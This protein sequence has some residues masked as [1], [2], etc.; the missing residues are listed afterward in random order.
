MH[1]WKDNGES[2]GCQGDR[3]WYLANALRVSVVNKD[4]ATVVAALAGRHV[5]SLRL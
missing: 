2:P 4:T 1:K 5:D 3:S